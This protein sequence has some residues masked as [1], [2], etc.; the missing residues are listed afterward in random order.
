M[1]QRDIG[2]KAYFEERERIK[3]R[4]LILTVSSYLLV[5]MVLA[6]AL[7]FGSIGSLDLRDLGSSSRAINGFFGGILTAIVL[8]ISLTS[9]TYTPRLM[10][11][12]VH[13]P[14][15]FFGL[16]LIL[17]CHLSFIVGAFIG[18]SHAL[19][20]LRVYV[21]ITLTCLVV[22]GVLPYLYYISN[23]MRPRFFL[24]IIEKE[25]I[26]DFKYLS[27][28]KWDKDKQAQIF[29]NI[30]VITNLAS[31]ASKRDDKSL[32]MVV[33]DMLIGILVELVELRK[34]DT[35]NWKVQSPVFLPGVS[36]EAQYHLEKNKTWPEYYILGKCL[37]EIKALDTNQTEIVS[38]FSE[39]LL[40]SMDEC[41]NANEDSLVEYHIM[42]LNTLL[43]ES[44]DAD[45]LSLFQSISYYYRLGIEILQEDKKHMGFAARSFIH[46][47][48]MVSKKKQLIWKETIMFDLGRI[49][50]F[51]GFVDERFGVGFLN[52]FAGTVW[53]KE[54]KRDDKISKVAWRAI[55]KTYWEAQSKGLKSLSSTIF[56]EYLKDDRIKHHETINYLLSH[57][58]ELHWEINDRLLSFNHLSSDAGRLAREYQSSELK[59]LL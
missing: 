35:T 38:F 53:R 42:A 14:P 55:V 46:Y 28:N 21:S 5:G 7:Y 18:P 39:R 16:A 45:D 27:L 54:Y 31:T 48:K 12:F 58:R 8:I 6:S 26:D 36:E 47:G 11:V 33:F 44:I 4:V 2:S 19:Y 43:R 1:G 34:E 49:I 25:V 20:E 30:N 59:D 29:E 37:R 15:A 32:I 10:S 51:F 24:P 52:D 3:K 57:V 50:L 17:L 23:F 41:L 56:E 9:N 40:K 13:Q 22:G